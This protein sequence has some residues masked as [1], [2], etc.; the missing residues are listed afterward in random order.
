V[1]AP[2]QGPDVLALIQKIH[3]N[4]D[5]DGYPLSRIVPKVI[6]VASLL[7]NYPVVVRYRLELVDSSSKAEVRALLETLNGRVD[8]TQVDLLKAAIINDWLTEREATMANVGIDAKEERRAVGQSIA[9]LEAAT[10]EIQ[11]GYDETFVTENSDWFHVLAQNWQ[12]QEVYDQR[13]EFFVILKDTE[14]VMARLRANITN[15]LAGAESSV[16]AALEAT[17]QA[18]R[19]EEVHVAS[20]VDKRKVFVVYGQDEAMRSAVFSFLRAAGLDPMEW[21]ELVMLTSEATGKATPYVGDIIE[22][23]MSQAQAVVVL[24]TGDEEAVLSAH[25]VKPGDPAPKVELQPRP[26]VILEAGMALLKYPERTILVEIGKVRQMSD[27]VGRYVLRLTNDFLKRKEFMDRL[28]TA[29]CAVNY[30]RNDWTSEGKLPD[31]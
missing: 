26:N 13:K 15:Y 8:P 9:S 24:F 19:V 4:L 7:G 23:G 2:G 14:R 10:K 29:G 27:V 31:A 30:S 11:K 18:G 12:K 16:I 5:Q 28:N 25:L 17:R 22:V 6:R 20:S 1:T 21:N 3:N